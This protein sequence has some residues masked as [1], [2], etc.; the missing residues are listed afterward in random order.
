MMA[1]W[2]LLGAFLVWRLLGIVPDAILKPMLACILLIS[3]VR[4]WK[5]LED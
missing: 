5:T 4:V 1:L 2:S 3:A